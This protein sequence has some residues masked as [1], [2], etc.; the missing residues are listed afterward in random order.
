ML[1]RF[2]LTQESKMDYLKLGVS[3][4]EQ[5]TIPMVH[6]TRHRSLTKY[7]QAKENIIQKRSRGNL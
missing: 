5:E 3:S 1:F 6:V 7:Q 2:L 4:G